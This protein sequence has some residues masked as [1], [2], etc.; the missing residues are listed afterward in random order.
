MCGRGPQFRGAFN[1]SLA[2]RFFYTWALS[3]V[4]RPETDGQTER[5]NR[6][7]E[8]VLRHFVS[9]TMTVWDEHL[10]LVQFAINSAWQEMVQETPH[11]LHFG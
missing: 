3:T 2:Q 7:I 1:Q 11:F 5:A 6:T 10:S 8:D 4:R 9:P